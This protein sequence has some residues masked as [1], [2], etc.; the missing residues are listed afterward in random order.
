M[1][2]FSTLYGILAGFIT[3]FVVAAILFSAENADL[4]RELLADCI[5]DSAE[6]DN[7]AGTLEQ[8]WETYYDT[9]KN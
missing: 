4:K 9:C 6:A 5:S 2:N 3:I 7:F 8:A 1:L